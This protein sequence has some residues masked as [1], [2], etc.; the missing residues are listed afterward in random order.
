[1]DPVDR[2]RL[3]G[4]VTLVTGASSGIGAALAA[5]LAQ[6]GARVV[7]AARREDR[8]QALAARIREAGGAAIAARM[9]VT[10]P[11]SVA[12][13]FEAAEKELG[14][15]QVVVNNA[16]VA[17]PKRFLKT[18]RESVQRV[19]DT[20]W[21]GVWNVCQEAARRMV[22]AGVGGSIVN[23]AS[24]LGL[25]AGVGYAAYSSSKAAVIHLT[26]SLAL[27]FAR[28]KIRVN[29]IAPG[30]FLTEMTPDY[31]ASAAGRE[32][33]AR[34]PPGRVGDVQ[35]LIGPVLLLASDAGSYVSGVVLPVDG[36]HS[37]ALV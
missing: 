29:A 37:V 20:N 12:A 25:G 14:T 11:A 5:G 15:V 33:I 8:L 18:D 24:I 21:F 13:A 26:R 19:T 31:L 30:W 10:D 32:H 27:E 36:A 4:K 17:E 3:D 16:G 7:L 34:T 2:F 22:A 1:M 9:D 28:Q 6:A 23:V 35:E